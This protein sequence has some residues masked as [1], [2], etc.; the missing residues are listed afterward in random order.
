MNNI[1]RIKR[2]HLAYPLPTSGFL[3]LRSLFIN[4]TLIRAQLM[5]QVVTLP[6]YRLFNQ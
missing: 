3:A 1:K 2:T 4:S 6:P 5:R